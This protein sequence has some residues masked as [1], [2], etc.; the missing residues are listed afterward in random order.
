MRMVMS[1]PS[2]S[3]FTQKITSIVLIAWQLFHSRL[4]KNHSNSFCYL[5]QQ[6]QLTGWFCEMF[7]MTLKQGSDIYKWPKFLLLTGL[8]LWVTS[9]CYLIPSASNQ[10]YQPDQPIPFSHKKHAGDLKMDCKYCHVGV[11]KSAAASVPALNVCMNCHQAVKT[12]SPHIQRLTEHYQ[13]GKPVQWERIHELPDFVRF[14]HQP[15]VL[16]GLDCVTCHGDVKTM[17]VVY[18]AEPLTMGWCMQCHRGET[19]PS[20]VLA[21]HKKFTDERGRHHVAPIR[22]STCHY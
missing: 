15:H 9:A 20:K 13:Q 1:L 16:A 19:T 11:D 6:W 14:S 10:G 5:G 4:K 18:Q 17:D 7:K 8:M 2:F 21:S 22:C 3:E 12:D